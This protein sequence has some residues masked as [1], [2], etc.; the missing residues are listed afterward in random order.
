MKKSKMFV[1]GLFHSLFWDSLGPEL[2][3]IWVIQNYPQSKVWTGNAAGQNTAKTESAWPRTWTGLPSQ[4]HKQVHPGW[5]WWRLTLTHSSHAKAPLPGINTNVEL[6]LHKKPLANLW[7]L[8]QAVGERGGDV[9]DAVM[10]WQISMKSRDEFKWRESTREG[11][12]SRTGEGSCQLTPVWS[13]VNTRLLW[14]LN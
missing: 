3:K 12:G 11:G 14:S 2:L 1:S 5:F 13:A 8:C 10:H 9:M 4:L 6:S 7:V